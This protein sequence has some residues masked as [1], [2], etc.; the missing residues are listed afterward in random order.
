MC[1]PQIAF[2]PTRSRNAS[3]PGH[4]TPGPKKGFVSS[5]YHSET[6]V[7]N[8]ARATAERCVPVY[9]ENA[10]APQKMT[11]DNQSSSLACQ[12]P[13]LQDAENAS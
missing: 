11:T 8:S 13:L 3:P 12:R 1:Y 9:K 7:K 2:S 4:R 10:M 5:I 6:S